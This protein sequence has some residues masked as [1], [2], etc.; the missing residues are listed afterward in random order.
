MTL[1]IPNEGRITQM[2]R[3]GCHRQRNPLLWTHRCPCTVRFRS[4][5]HASTH[6]RRSFRRSMRICLSQTCFHQRTR[7]HSNLHLRRYIF[8]SHVFC[9]FANLP[10]RRLQCPSSKCRVL[11]FYLLP[12]SHG[13]YRHY[14][15][16]TILPPLWGHSSTRLS[17]HPYWRISWYQPRSCHRSSNCRC[18]L[19]RSLWFY[20]NSLRSTIA[21]FH[22]VF[23]VALIDDVG[24]VSHDTVAVW[25]VLAEPSFEICSISVE[26]LSFTFF[27]S[28]PVHTYKPI[29]IIMHN[30]C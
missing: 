22:S 16:D 10:C 26:D 18:I 5:C 12:K 8:R 4:F 1:H 30:F 14:C 9:R 21:V 11:P 24:W 17:T 28:V 2:A 20:L 13:N 7:L 29:P 25:F 23:E 3:L 6:L 15:N 27:H 19:L